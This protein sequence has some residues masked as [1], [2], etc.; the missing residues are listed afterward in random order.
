M[1]ENPKL[2]TVNPDL[3]S[4]YQPR[5]SASRIQ[6]GT[7]GKNLQGVFDGIEKD[8]ADKK[9]ALDQESDEL[10]TK[11]AEIELNADKTF[12]D[13]VLEMATNLKKNLLMQQKL[14][15]DGRIPPEKFRQ[16][17]QKAKDQMGQFGIMAKSAQEYTD[18]AVKRQQDNTAG[19]SETYLQESNQGFN[20]L[21]GTVNWM[22][23]GTNTMYIVRLDANGNMPSY[24]D[25]PE[26]YLPASYANNRSKYQ[27]NREN[28]DISAQTASYKENMMTLIKSWKSTKEVN[29]LEGV[30]TVSQEDVRMN[31]TQ[32]EEMKNQLF[33]S[34]FNYDDEVL[35]NA[36]A[37]YDN[38]FAFAQSEEE[39]KKNNPGVDL[40]YWIKVDANSYPPKFIPN[41]RKFMEEVVRDASD[42]AFDNQMDSMVKIDGGMTF[43]QVNQPNA[44][45]V[46]TNQNLQTGIGYLQRVNDI[47]AGDMSA[48]SSASAA[49]IIDM[50]KGKT[51]PDEMIDSIK[52]I[53]DQL[54]IEYQSGRKE[55]V[56]RKDANGNIRTTEDMSRQI[57]QLVSPG[58]INGQPMSYDDIEAEFLKK[59]QF[60]VNARDMSDAEITTML[61]TNK[62]KEQLIQA[63]ATSANPDPNYQPTPKEIEAAAKGITIG[64]N[65]IAE[66]KK[67][68]IPQGYTGEDAVGFSSRTPYTIKGA[69]EA[70]IRKQGDKMPSMTGVASLQTDT[71]RTGKTNLET[72]IIAGDY[73]KRRKKEYE[74]SVAKVYKAYI[75]SALRK[76]TDITIDGSTG[77]LVVNYKGKSVAIPGVTDTE[78]DSNLTYVK[79]D[80]MIAEAA[81]QIVNK[82]NTELANRKGGK[83]SAY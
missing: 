54:I 33:Q 21:N 26:S 6:W 79:L 12:S 81:Q 55:P 4:I 39:F 78:L 45:S 18:N 9:T 48:F 8:K 41:D 5:D 71:N 25:S 1:A 77:K 69:G 75:P 61:K 70:I 51:D 73:N 65:D 68:G 10:F 62:A 43:P 15:K 83:P 72:Y 46:A 76:D 82:R 60:T 29:G 38:Q 3:Y 23:P 47:V 17:M 66:A 57:F 32:F 31:K 20:N 63:N 2:N 28:A 16:L 80:Q 52:R 13:S 14:M 49:G 67:N 36:A 37:Q 11:V 22:D 7:I 42:Q 59:R 74:G 19:A 40:K 30:Y 53:G 64:A 24:E 27:F 35:S 58:T 50:N 34:K 44:I 56:D